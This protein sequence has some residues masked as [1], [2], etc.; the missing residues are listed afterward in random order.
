M[1]RL[2]FLFVD[3]CGVGRRG[4]SNPF[5]LA[6]CRHLPFWRG[7]LALA[8]GSPV[9]ALDATLG[10]PGVP[11]SASGQTALFCGANAA[12]LGGRHRNGYPDRSLRRVIREK[13]LLSRLA[14]R[15]ARACFLNAYP[16]FDREF[17]SD[18][19]RLEP[20]GR[21]WFSDRFPERFR[22]FI[23]VTSCMLL[24]SDQKPFGEG[25]I[26]SG[27]ALYQDYSNRQL[28]A[29]G[30]SLPPFSPRRAA[31]VL[32]GA[33]RRLDF[34]LYEYFQTDLYAHRHSLE[35]CVALVRD[36]DVLVGS[37]LDRLDRG[38]DTL[39]LTSDHGNLEEYHQR[40]HS[41]NPVPLI[42]WG[43]HG[44]RLRR[45]IKSISDVAPALLELYD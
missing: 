6:G 9:T 14:A 35:E 18:H 22:R 41:R 36:L 2:I 1:E 21:L 19:V 42:A 31:R 8:D 7:G 4:G 17:T 26:R 28:I 30:F 5:F 16:A 32:H 24:A 34:V 20:D 27:K 38:R 15:K 43:R 39:V 11:Q 25:D 40:G 44:A 10:I 45:K 37:L 23:S 13:N 12:E 3:G 33:S 29:R